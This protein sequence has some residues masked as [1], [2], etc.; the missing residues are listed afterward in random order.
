MPDI[1]VDF[2]QD[3][4]DEV[5]EYVAREVRRASNVCQIITFGT[6]EGAKRVITRRRPRARTCRY[7]DA[8]GSPS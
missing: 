5:I 4:R 6:H 2:C 1:D 8:T 7:A 3:R